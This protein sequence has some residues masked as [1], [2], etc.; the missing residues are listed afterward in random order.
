[1]EKPK[2]H[3][4]D[5]TCRVTGQTNIIFFKAVNTLRALGMHKECED[6][7]NRTR[8]DLPRKEFIRIISEYFDFEKSED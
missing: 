1:M 6:L 8:G 4:L 2:L 3:F 5:E 7:I